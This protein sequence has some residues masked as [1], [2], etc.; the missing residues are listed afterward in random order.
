MSTST[1]TPSSRRTGPKRQQSW[2]WS[3]PVEANDLEDE[4]FASQLDRTRKSLTK[5][6]SLLESPPPKPPRKSNELPYKVK[7][8]KTKDDETSWL[9]DI[10]EWLWGSDEIAPVKQRISTNRV[11]CG[12]CGNGIVSK[13]ERCEV[14]GRAY[15]KLCLR[16]TRCKTPLPEPSGLCRSCSRIV[17]A[18]RRAS[19]A[20]HVVGVTERTSLSPDEKGD[21]RGVLGEIG[22]ELEEAYRN[23]IARCDVCGAAFKIKDKVHYQVK[24]DKLVATA[25]QECHD[26]GR[27]RDGRVHSAKPPRLAIKAAPDRVVLK[28]SANAKA[29]TLFFEKATTALAT[30]PSK[31]H[32]KQE[33]LAPASVD[34][35]PVNE[36]TDPARAKQRRERLAA[37]LEATDLAC[38]VLGDDTFRHQP[39]PPKPAG[40]RFT[41]NLRACKD[42]LSHDLAVHFDASSTAAVPLLAKLAVS[43][44]SAS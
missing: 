9:P 11:P 7:L 5:S 35:K 6:P 29:T 43:I 17:D 33:N 3:D 36:P 44:A 21:V 31:H 24:G 1:T 16:C 10:S 27:P 40:H 19:R 12:I 18:E 25:H 23:Q 38:A 2:W 39:Q 32:S 41:I 30:P 34:Y 8:R 26:L 4:S 22:D 13:F 42:R 28:V 15:H 14:G 20:D 37:I